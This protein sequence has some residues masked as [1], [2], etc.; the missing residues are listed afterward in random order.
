MVKTMVIGEPEKFSLVKK[1]SSKGIIHITAC[2]LNL[3]KLHYGNCCAFLKRKV[4]TG[5]KEAGE[6][7]YVGNISGNLQHL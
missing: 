6:K 7:N 5:C 4:G 1:N 3:M 2:S